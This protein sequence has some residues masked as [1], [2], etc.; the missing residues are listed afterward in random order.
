MVVLGVKLVSFLLKIIWSNVN[1]WHR[2]LCECCPVSLL[3]EV[4]LSESVSDKWQSYLLS[5]RLDIWKTHP[6]FHSALHTKEVTH[7]HKHTHTNTNKQSQ[8]QRNTN[9]LSK[10]LFRP[11]APWKFHQ[12]PVSIISIVLGDKNESGLLIAA[13][14]DGT[15]RR[16]TKED[17]VV[18][19]LL[20]LKLPRFP[21]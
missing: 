3:I 6:Q 14:E 9:T 7:K 10:T 17:N 13:R 18:S 15:R 5:C 19:N 12:N 8:T 21:P 1:I 11:N 4:S 20:P 16:G 2:K